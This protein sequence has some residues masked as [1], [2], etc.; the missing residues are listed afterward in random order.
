MFFVTDHTNYNL[1]G[2][3]NTHED[4]SWIDLPT[5]Q[6]RETQQNVCHG[7]GQQGRLLPYV[8]IHGPK[9]IS[10]SEASSLEA[11]A[12]ASETKSG[13]EPG[14]DG[15]AAGEQVGAQPSARSGAPYQDNSELQSLLHSLDDQYTSRNNPS[16]VVPVMCPR[17]SMR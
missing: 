7:D 14:S 3:L 9:P 2:E 16:P 5:R 12:A 17:I 15:M 1:Q 11:C 6:P 8:T 13:S 10:V 4:Y